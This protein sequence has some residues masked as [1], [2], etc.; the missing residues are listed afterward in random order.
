MNV[1]E[2]WTRGHH[3][4]AIFAIAARAELLAIERA[5]HDADDAAVVAHLRNAAVL[6]RAIAAAQW[7]A[8]DFPPAVYRD[9][10][11]PTMVATGARGGFSGTQNADY[12]RLKEAREIAVEALFAA[13]GSDGSAW[14]PD[15]YA[16]LQAL[17]EMEVQ[18]AEHHVLVAASKVDVDQSLAQKAQ[19]ARES[20]VD[21]LREVVDATVV[22]LSDRFTGAPHATTFACKIADVPLERPHRVSVAGK[23]LVIAHAY[24]TFW[25]TDAYCTHADADLA[26]G[27]MA[28]DCIVCPLH[29]SKFDPRTG[30]VLREP[31]KDPLGVYPV[32]LDGDS[33]FVQ[34]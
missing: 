26:D 33:L 34:L 12:R 27:H 1:V 32:V 6:R 23:D 5:L 18:A 10:L 25:A 31:A 9:T 20:A 21:V 11:R 13:Y 2:R 14:P 30:A 4:F 29:G 16:A 22:D 17:H 24:G 19:G 15:V 3:T 7:Y 28:G 8:S